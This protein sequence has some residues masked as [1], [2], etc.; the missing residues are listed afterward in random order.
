MTLFRCSPHYLIFS[1]LALTL[2][3]YPIHDALATVRDS[4]KNHHED[5]EIYRK[6]SEWHGEGQNLAKLKGR[7]GWD[8]D[9]WK[10]LPM[11][12][13][14]YRMS[15]TGI[16]WFVYIEADTSLSWSNLLYHLRTL[17]PSQ[18]VYTGAQNLIENTEFAHGGR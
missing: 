6:L 7:K 16:D 4:T 15:P 13:E 10:F 9:K 18:L 17:D 14:T 1:D 2:S 3:D 11:M 5:F 12:H 8:L